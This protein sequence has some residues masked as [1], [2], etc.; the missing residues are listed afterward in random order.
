[1][2][3]MSQHVLHSYKFGIGFWFNERK[4][5]NQGMGSN[6]VLLLDLVLL[7]VGVLALLLP[8]KTSKAVGSSLIIPNRR[9]LH[10]NNR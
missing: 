4:K 7:L 3:Q 6:T 8:L 1:M 9:F 2:K 5:K 10:N